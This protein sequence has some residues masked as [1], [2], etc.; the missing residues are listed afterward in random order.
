MKKGIHK[1]AETYKFD[2]GEDSQFVFLHVCKGFCLLSWRSDSL[3]R[4]VERVGP[5]RKGGHNTAM[6][7]FHKACL[8][9]EA[10]P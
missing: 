3:V 8:K 5:I 2:V 6:R 10:T 4:Y 9:M 7:R 1:L